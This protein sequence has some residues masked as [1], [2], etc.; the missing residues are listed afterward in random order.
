MKKYFYCAVFLLITAL[1]IC[2]PVTA[3]YA[4]GIKAA[5]ELQKKVVEITQKSIPSYVFIGGGSGVIISADGYVLTNYHV[6]EKSKADKLEAYTANGKSYEAKIIGYDPRGD[7]ALLKLNAKEDLPY[8]E[9]GDSD[10]V[11]IGQPVIALGNPFGMAMYDSAPTLTFGVISAMHL[12]Q[13]TYSDAIQTDAPINPGNSGGPLITL[14]G[15]VVGINGKIEMRFGFIVANTGI[16]YAI[17]ANQVKKFLP[18]LKD[19]GRVA[20]GEI[21][22]LDIKTDLDMDAET[23]KVSVKVTGIAKGSTADKAGFKEGDYIIKVDE[24]FVY[25]DRRFWGVIGVYPAGSVVNIKLKMDGKEVTLPVTLKARETIME[26]ALA[27][28]NVPYLGIRLAKQEN[29]NLVLIEEIDAGSPAAKSDLKE[30]DIILELAGEKVDNINHLQELIQ[31]HKPGDEVEIKV[32]RGPEE[33]TIK[34]ILEEKQ[35]D[36]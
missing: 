6:I 16:G 17:P 32:R 3:D 9:L 20:H 29:N 11:K 23:N 36:N 7:I 12:N 5:K 33:E 18:K 19:G 27:H 4:D 21:K 34:I 24:Y 14:D 28:D 31:K 22:G 13:D 2:Q 1:F 15:K 10:S 26:T 8:L 30:G 35:R 25:S